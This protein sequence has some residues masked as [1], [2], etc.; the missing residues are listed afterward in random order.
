MK[1]KRTLPTKPALRVLPK[2][3]S[4]METLKAE[5]AEIYRKFLPTLDSYSAMAKQVLELQ[6][7]MFDEMIRNAVPVAERTEDSIIT[8]ISARETPANMEGLL[9][10][11]AKQNIEVVRINYDPKSF[12]FSFCG[13]CST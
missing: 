1:T 12:V 8:T 4:L 13:K 6:I 9:A 2:D 10:Q 11:L 7:Q 5:H 3:V